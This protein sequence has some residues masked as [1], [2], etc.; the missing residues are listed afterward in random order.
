[1]NFF[2]P[3]WYDLQMTD[4]SPSMPI[5][6]LASLSQAQRERMAYIDF[7]L[8]FLGE[9]TRSDLMAR[10]GI[11]T[12]AATR[13]I[14]LYRDLAPNN[15]ILGRN[16]AYRPSKSFT[17]LLGFESARVLSALTQEGS[18]DLLSEATAPLVRSARMT[19]LALPRL[20]TLAPVTRA[21]NLKQIVKIGYIS[22][23]S[24]FSERE[25]APFAIF[26][27]GARWYMRAYCRKR[28]TFVDF[29][30]RRITSAEIVE[31][32]YAKSHE[33]AEADTQW[34]RIID[35][36]LVVHPSSDCPEMVALDYDLVDGALKVQARASQV[37]YL[38]RHWWVDCSVDHRL[39]SRQYEL[40][41]KDSL[42][43]YGAS[44]AAVAPREPNEAS[45]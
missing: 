9:F 29:A 14:A 33:S 6:T 10:F 28:S 32:S 36:E 1:M 4:Q 27:S 12:A 38:L 19:A 45:K 23:E 18:V 26:D 30:L 35:L 5:K 15:A 17:P 13:D 42:S 31:E 8:F 39:P 20:E 44:S 11:A 25:V 40:W 37:G 3:C 34:S 22:A 24:G 21:I 7:R 16:K 43:I 41:L 2:D